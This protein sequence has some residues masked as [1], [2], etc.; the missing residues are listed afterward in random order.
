MIMITKPWFY[1]LPLAYPTTA[2]EVGFYLLPADFEHGEVYYWFHHPSPGDGGN[3]PLAC[4]GAAVF[5]AASAAAIS[6]VQFSCCLYHC[7]LSLSPHP[8]AFAPASLADIAPPSW[9]HC[10][11]VHLPPPAPL[12]EPVASAPF[13]PPLPLRVL[14]SLHCYAR[15]PR[16]CTSLCTDC[17][18]FCHQEGQQPTAPAGASA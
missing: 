4:A 11:L 5:A 13:L 7:S 8:P 3:N 14:L 17:Y 15:S 18:P 2:K 16:C 6:I 10:C 12:F 9:S 1:L